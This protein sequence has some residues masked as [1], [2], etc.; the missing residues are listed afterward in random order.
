MN[1]TTAKKLC[2]ANGELMAFIKSDSDM[3]DLK[4]Y[5]NSTGGVPDDDMFIGIRYNA[6]SKVFKWLDKQDVTWAPWDDNEPDCM[7]SDPCASTSNQNCVR[8]TTSYTF[9]SFRC[10]SPYY[11]LCGKAKITDETARSI[12]SAISILEPTTLDAEITET[13]VRARTTPKE[14]VTENTAIT[15]KT[16]AEPKTDTNAITHI[17]SAEHGTFIAQ[18]KPTEHETETTSIV[19][20]KP[21]EHV[22]ENTSIFQMTAAKYLT[23]TTAITQM[24][25]AEFVTETTVIAQ[26]TSAKHLTETT[27]KSQMEL[28]EHVTE[29]TAITQVTSAE[30]VT[31]TRFMTSAEHLTE[32]TTKTRM[33]PAEHL[34]ETTAIARMTSAEHESESTIIAQKKYSTAYNALNCLCPNNMLGSK[35]LNIYEMDLTFLELRHIIEE[36]FKKKIKDNISVDKN[37]LSKY[38]RSKTSATDDRKSSASFG[39]LS[40]ALICIPVVFVVS[41]DLLNVCISDSKKGKRLRSMKRSH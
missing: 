1:F 9:R 29:I 3:N 36:D 21:T 11:V 12:D 30:L 6:E 28:T 41:I 35:W 15:Q 34:T 8:M 40:V 33:A 10:N 20:I 14:H 17:A 32:T 27:A 13:T 31:E 23:D 25:T 37:T 7:G 16:P 39:W 2:V 18:I 38:V 26:T 24:T 19:Q 22:T 4:Q 5:F